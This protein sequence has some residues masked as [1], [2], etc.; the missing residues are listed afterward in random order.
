M[1]LPVS[2]SAARE[3]EGTRGRSFAVLPEEMEEPHQGHAAPGI[4]LFFFFF[5]RASPLSCPFISLWRH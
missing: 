1:L 3:K 5:F 4:F 2:L